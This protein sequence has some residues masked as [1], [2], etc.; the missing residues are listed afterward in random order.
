MTLQRNGSSQRQIGK[1]AAGGNHR[2][3]MNSINSGRQDETFNQ[4]R[5]SIDIHG[6]NELKNFI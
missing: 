5:E 6:M 1:L 3:S 4:V 2:N